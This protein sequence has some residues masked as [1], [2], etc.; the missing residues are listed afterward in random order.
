MHGIVYGKQ[1]ESNAIELASLSPFFV[2]EN[3]SVLREQISDL[4]V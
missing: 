3:I 2:Y 4:E 1:L